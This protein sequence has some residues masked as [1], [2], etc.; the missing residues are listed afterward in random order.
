MG[1]FIV[2]NNILIAGFV[3]LGIDDDNEN[4]FCFSIDFI[5]ELGM[6]I[7]SVYFLI[8]DIFIVDLMNGNFDLMLV[9]VV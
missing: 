5:I 6:G 7:V 2:Q 3:E 9:G 4:F 8:F 1:D